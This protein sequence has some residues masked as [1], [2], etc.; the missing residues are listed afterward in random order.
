MTAQASE[1]FLA[2]GQKCLLY[3]EPLRTLLERHKLSIKNPYVKSTANYRGYTG[4]WEIRSGDLYLVDVTWTHLNKDPRGGRRDTELPIS[5]EAQQVLFAAAS[6]T[7]FPVHASWC[8][9]RLM[10][11]YGECRSRGMGGVTWLG[12]HDKMREVRIRKGRVARDRLV[13]FK[14]YEEWCERFHPDS[15]WAFMRGLWKYRG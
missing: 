7:G 1:V 2:D 12:W 10:I 3:S 11:G 15:F 8:S 14:S 9:G 13:L 6:A 4:T 5:S